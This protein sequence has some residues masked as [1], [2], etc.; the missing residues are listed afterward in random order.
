M[1]LLQSSPLLFLSFICIARLSV[2]ELG[3]QPA[4]GVGILDADCHHALWD[5]ATQSIR[6]DVWHAPRDQ[7]A[8]RHFFSRDP[9]WIAQYRMPQGFAYRTCSV[10]IDILDPPPGVQPQRHVEGDWLDMWD[11]FVQILRHCV[12]RYGIGGSARSGSFSF[13]IINPNTGL[14][15][16]LCMQSNL[17]IAMNMARCIAERAQRAEEAGLP[18]QQHPE[19]EGEHPESEQ[20]PSSMMDTGESRVGPAQR[21]SL[22]GDSSVYGGTGSG[23][24]PYP[25]PQRATVSG[26]SG[27]QSPSYDSSEV[28]GPRA[29]S[30]PI[31]GMV[32][33]RAPRNPRWR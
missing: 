19:S 17:N 22:S 13:T 9:Y 26:P 14:G 30:P 28:Q 2:A 20:N 23:F 1:L 24:G 8:Q 11:Q 4:F 27:T 32:Q 33:P 5:W 10:G 12:V 15:R 18:A 31:E 7:P 6:E 16:G 25:L 3:C 29:I 21:L